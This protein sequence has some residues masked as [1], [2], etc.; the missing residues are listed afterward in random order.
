MVFCGVIVMTES[1]PTPN[2][3]GRGWTDS[4]AIDDDVVGW[5]GIICGLD[6][7]GSGEPLIPPPACS[8]G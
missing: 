4:A 3:L 7:G 1:P 8:C 6:I 2:R 5:G